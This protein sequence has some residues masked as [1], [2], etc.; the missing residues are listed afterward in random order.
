MAEAV[1]AGALPD[2]RIV[3]GLVGEVL[4]RLQ[5]IVG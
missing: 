3:P 5:R 4:D 1:I 2:A